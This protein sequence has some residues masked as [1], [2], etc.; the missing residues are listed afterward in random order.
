MNRSKRVFPFQRFRGP[1]I[2]VL[3][4]VLLG[5][6]A[7][8]SL[9]DLAEVPH[10][11]LANVE[12]AA[13]Q[14]IEERKE[15]LERALGRGEAPPLVNAFGDL[16]ET[17]QAYGLTGA[18]DVSYANA[19]TLEPEGFS[20]PYLRGVVAQEGGDFPAAVGHFERALELRS[21]SAQAR[22]R[23]GEIL[24]AQGDAEGAA[25]QFRR[26]ADEG[27]FGAASAY[28]LGRA[29][30]SMGDPEAAVGHFQDA[31]DRQPGAGAVRHPMGLALAQLGRTEEA[32]SYLG[33]RSA[34]GEVTFPD[35]LVDRVRGLAVSSGVLLRRGNQALM[36]GRLD[37]A[38]DL[39]AKGVEVNPENVELRLNLA[40]T[41][42]RNE[43]I[44]DALEVLRA[45]AELEPDNP[46]VQHDLGAAYRTK[47]RFDLAAEA[48]GRATELQP[49]YT[50]A[51]F[52]L[53]N[54][55]VAL[56]RWDD[57]ATSADRTLELD[58][59]DGRAR[60]L[61]A[62]ARHQQGDSAAAAARLR[63][64]VADEPDNLVAREGLGTVLEAL[65]QRSQAVAAFADGL[66]L[67]L[68][69]EARV[70]WLDKTARIAWR[71]NR[72]DEALGHWREITELRPDSSSAFTDYANALQL[73]GQRAEART[74][75]ATAIELDPS[76]VTARLS[77]A[78]LLILEGDFQ[79]AKNRLEA[80]HAQAP[81]DAAVVHTLARLLATCPVANLRDGERA[82]DLA[83]QAYALESTLERAETV[84]MALAE[85]G[86][87]EEAIR[88][89]RGLVRQAQAQGDQ[90]LL[91]GLVRHLRMY[92]NRQPVRATV[93]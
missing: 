83:R 58:P 79:S 72:R 74:H 89:Q 51:H 11:D 5:C 34:A 48:L 71:Y 87:F 25:D 10:P 17:Y 4:A 53:A 60:Y 20:W 16:G 92:E 69:P 65:G 63:R 64:L 30:A 36:A 1:A 9:P 37:E 6:P 8:P 45:A 44:D 19:Q 90:R 2:L 56:G 13:R 38:A 32:E 28:G 22:A 77:E 84:A 88:F 26:I 78:S 29:A 18:A 43:K 67:D 15:A 62:M 33:G 24:L 50:S 86:K 23:L 57:V 39:F 3:A 14:Q 66:A 85:M 47:G 40:L 31:L 91:Q 73:A 59:A 41:H 61:A 35:P 27:G 81:Q 42:V 46:R 52:N 49:D 70:S 76:N 68:D 7:P 21:Q 80:A 55:M 82:F 12:P 54:V 75:F 93:Q